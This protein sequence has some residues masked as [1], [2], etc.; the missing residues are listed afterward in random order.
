[1]KFTLVCVLQSGYLSI[2]VAIG[3]CSASDICCS[4]AAQ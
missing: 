4:R 3:L 2:D 1:M